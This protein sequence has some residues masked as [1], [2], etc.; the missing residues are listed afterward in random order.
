[1]SEKKET[2]LDRDLIC[3]MLFCFSVGFMTIL[4]SL[5]VAL[6]YWSD[7]KSA[8][9]EFENDPAIRNFVALSQ[10][11]IFGV[12]PTLGVG[13][14][15]VGYINRKTYRAIKLANNARTES[16]DSSRPA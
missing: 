9:A 6:C 15:G 7:M 3:T 2:I 4:F 8:V 1:M 12:L 5:C 14:L 11:L 10:L 13:F 16:P